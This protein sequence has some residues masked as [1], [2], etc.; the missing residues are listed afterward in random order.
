MIIFLVKINYLQDG[1]VIESTINKYSV[2]NFYHYFPKH[3]TGVLFSYSFVKLRWN[4][5]NFSY[6]LVNLKTI[7]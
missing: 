6:F 7:F 1:K 2:R 4:F 3:V 5:I